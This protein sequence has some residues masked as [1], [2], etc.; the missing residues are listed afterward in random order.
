MR[1]PAEQQ[2]ARARALRQLAAQLAGAGALGLHQR[3]GDDAWVGPLADRCRDD[4]FTVRREIQA[5][6]DDLVA[7]ARNLE[8]QA[9]EAEALATMPGRVA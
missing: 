3:A 5:A 8:R 9:A 7:A 1:T 6:R 4:L 2:R